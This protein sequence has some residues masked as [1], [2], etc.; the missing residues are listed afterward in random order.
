MIKSNTTNTAGTPAATNMA[1]SG[2]GVDV[3][4][5]CCIIFASQMSQHC[6]QVCSIVFSTTYTKL[7]V[8]YTMISNQGESNWIK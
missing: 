7:L 8:L 2:I 4:G 3:G 6:L 5:S 1:H